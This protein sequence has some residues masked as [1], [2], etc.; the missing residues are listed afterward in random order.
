MLSLHI[1]KIVFIIIIKTE[2]KQV[3][4]IVYMTS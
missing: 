2:Q 4:E 1:E 3:K